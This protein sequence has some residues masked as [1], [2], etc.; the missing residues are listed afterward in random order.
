MISYLENLFEVGRAI[1]AWLSFVLL[2]ELGL[3]GE[4]EDAVEEGT[5]PVDKIFH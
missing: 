2:Q 5:E 1:C 4:I 3:L